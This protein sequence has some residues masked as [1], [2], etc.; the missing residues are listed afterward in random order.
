MTHSLCRSCALQYDRLRP[1]RRLCESERSANWLAHGC[2]SRGG[3]RLPALNA[4][5]TSIFRVG[6]V[7]W[8]VG[9]SVAGKL[10]RSRRPSLAI[11][12]V[13]SASRCSWS[14]SRDRL[15]RP[16]VRGRPRRRPRP[17]RGGEL[18][19]SI[20]SRTAHLQP[21]RRPQ[22]R[23]RLARASHPGDARP[24]ESRTDT[25]EPWLAE[26][27]T[28]S[29]DHLTFTIKLRPGVT[30]SDGVPFTSADVLFSFRALYDPKVQSAL[31]ARHAYRRKALAG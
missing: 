21:L 22:R 26:S 15:S 18:V 2:S 8:P 5:K 14:R 6:Q 12:A 3:Y 29:P 27:W 13:A 23:R 31:A 30:F 10:S 11:V 7:C 20:R 19:A 25:L 16:T 1:C 4:R 9:S 17:V 24:G 28:E